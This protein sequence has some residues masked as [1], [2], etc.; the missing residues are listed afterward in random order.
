MSPLTSVLAVAR[1]ASSTP[2]GPTIDVFYNF[3]GGRSWTRRQHPLG[4]L[5][6]MF[7]TTSL[8]AAARPT[9]STA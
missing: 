4:G 1:P 6:S 7:P 2:R 3:D 8:V 9:S 5:P